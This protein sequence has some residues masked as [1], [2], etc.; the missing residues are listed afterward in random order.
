MR[1]E[2]FN[3]ATAE[4]GYSDMN[5]VDMRVGLSVGGIRA[6]FLNKFVMDLLVS[7]WLRL[8]YRAFNS[9]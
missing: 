9:L 2:M 4:D 3:G 7:S 8:P 6:V 1:L 5:A